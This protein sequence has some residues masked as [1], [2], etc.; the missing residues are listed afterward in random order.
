LRHKHP[1]ITLVTPSLNQGSFIAE[2]IESVAAQ[3]YPNLE[4]FV[5]DGG[6]SDQ[7]GEVVSRY[8]SI[9]TDYVCESDR[10]QANAIN[11]G[12]ARG[13]GDILCWLNADDLLEPRALETISELYQAGGFAFVYGDG[14]K[15]L[16]GRSWRRRIRAGKVDPKRLTVRDNILQ[17]STFWSRDVAE[18]IGGLDETLHYVFDWDFFV[19]VAQSFPMRYV[20]WPFSTYRIHP[21]Q[22]SSS[23]GKARAAEIVEVV[24]RYA[25][26]EWKSAFDD[27]W[28]RYDRMS[29]KRKIVRLLRAAEL[30]IREP[31]LL[32]RHGP[33]RLGLAA[34]SLL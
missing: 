24:H 13:S 28:L 21:T 2:T 12:L 4:Y 19:R 7:T 15:R 29:G 23:G 16:H 8:S 18:R 30:V 31:T 9:I 27:L 3:R 17:P 33:G 22:K 20:P 26:P 14:W 10:G 5:I 34:L 11:K 6:S 25:P 32:A 1:R